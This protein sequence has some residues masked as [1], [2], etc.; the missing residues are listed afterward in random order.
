MREQLKH[1]WFLMPFVSES[2][3][4]KA[5]LFSVIYSERVPSV[6]VI[7]SFTDSECLFLTRKQFP[8]NTKIFRRKEETGR[9]AQGPGMIAF[10]LFRI[11]LQRLG[12]SFLG[13]PNASLTLSGYLLTVNCNPKR[14]PMGESDTL[15]VRKKLSRSSVTVDIQRSHS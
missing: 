10:C 3:P 15:S 9:H 13:W 11:S 8:A 14:G 12:D 7:N 5:W 6:Y 1:P 2:T 4:G